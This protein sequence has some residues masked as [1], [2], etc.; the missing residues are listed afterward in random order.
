LRQH[1]PK[2]EIFNT[3]GHAGDVFLFDSNGAH[4]GN[5]RPQAAVRDT[6]F[7]EYT[8][9]RS[10]VWG[11]DIDAATVAALPPDHPSTGCWPQEEMDD[12]PH[13]RI[14]PHWVENLPQVETG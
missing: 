5:R 14:R 7:I 11:C 8:T 1:L 9:E 4:R 2:V 3:V 10:D 12:R 13:V 6:L